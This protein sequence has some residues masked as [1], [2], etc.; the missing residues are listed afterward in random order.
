MKLVFLASILTLSTTANATWSA[1]RLSCKTTGDVY[2]PLTLEADRLILND[3]G[4][5][6][7]DVTMTAADERKTETGR[8]KEVAPLKNYNPRKYKNH[9]KFEMHNQLVDTESFG[10]FWPLDQ[11]ALNVMI[12]ND[13]FEKVSFQAPVVMNCD[14]SGGTEVL[15][16]ELTDIKVD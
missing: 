5:F 10:K 14:Q 16:C 12:P 9:S 7:R 15:E 1:G 11:C 13:A 4:L 8:A 2:N 3:D 6:M